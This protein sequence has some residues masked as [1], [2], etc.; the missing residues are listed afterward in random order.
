[1]S[2]HTKELPKLKAGD[3]V[4]IQN[5]KGTSKQTKRWDRS[6]VALEVSKFDKYVVR[7][8]GTGRIKMRNR[9]FLRKAEPYQSR[10]PGPGPEIVKGPVQE[11]LRAALVKEME[12]E[13][14]E[15]KE[16]TIPPWWRNQW[17]T[18]NC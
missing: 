4:L 1:M 10:Q 11:L 16:D 7:V 6:G 12:Q 13:R 18:Q 2:E 9:R 3:V 15:R 14:G 8:E 5:Q 17:R